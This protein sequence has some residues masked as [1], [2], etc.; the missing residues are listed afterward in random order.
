[1]SDI[2]SSYDFL[3]S[4]LKTGKIRLE[5]D[6]ASY[7]ELKSSRYHTIQTVIADLHWSAL[8]VFPS[9]SSDSMK[10]RL[11]IKNR[12][13]ETFK[14]KGKLSMRLEDK[15]GKLIEERIYSK[16]ME[17]SARTLLSRPTVDL[18]EIPSFAQSLRDDNKVILE[19]DIETF[20]K[21]E[22]PVDRLKEIG[23]IILNIGGRKLI[24]NRML[25]SIHSPVFR[26]L[27]KD[28]TITEYELEDVDFLDFATL[29]NAIVPDAYPIPFT[30]VEGVLK[31]AQKFEMHQIVKKCR[32]VIDEFSQYITQ[33]T[34]PCLF[35]RMQAALNVTD[36]PSSS[37]ENH[38]RNRVDFKGAQFVLQSN[39]KILAKAISA[40]GKMAEDVYL[41]V[42]DGGL[43]LKVLNRSKS[44]YCVFRFAPEFFNDCDLSLI[45]PSAVNVCRMSMKAAQSMFK[46]IHLNDKN[47]LACEFRVDPKSDTMG[48][49][50]GLSYDITR[51][52]NIKLLEFSGDLVRPKYDRNQYRNCTVLF[53]SILT[54]ILN[55][56]RNEGEVTLFCEKEYLQLKN[57]QTSGSENLTRM[58]ITEMRNPKRIRTETKISVEKLSRHNITFSTEISFSLKEFSAVVIF[59]EYLASE[60]CLYY[61]TP[62]KPL[63]IAV[64]SST[65]F[66]VELQLATSCPDDDFDV[67]G[68]IFGE[69]STK[70]P[71]PVKT[72]RRGSMPSQSRNIDVEIDEISTNR[73][74]RKIVEHTSHEGD[75][76]TTHN[77][78]WR[79]KEIRLPNQEETTMPALDLAE[80][81]EPMEV[82][83]NGSE[84]RGEFATLAVEP[85]GDAMQALPATPPP[86]DEMME[87]DAEPA[88]QPEEVANKR[89]N[90]YDMKKF[91]MKG[92]KKGGILQEDLRDQENNKKKYT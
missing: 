72:P 19:I 58:N 29:Q 50:L 42:T 91:A 81:D 71:S 66:D 47:F 3:P 10:T 16:E 59:A 12:E 77:R 13:F 5:M 46:G 51:T 69:N 40:L 33:T 18:F 90:I 84:L 23:D 76:E 85:E 6:N 65:S 28:S 38:Q 39:L 37:S 44:A 22:V 53:A 24:S 36:N 9:A 21:F 55:Q 2:L 4:N 35:F 86:H 54:P 49:Q 56:L 75:A 83:E 25:L 15:S 79:E 32:N 73:T 80:N 1:M 41:E 27:L 92:K 20:N 70:T 74:K 82:A 78:T 8:F 89:V 45:N 57:F 30:N 63:I 67:D 11:S 64:E 43:M 87:V 52:I 26:E 88:P 17:F 31:L 60:V 62:G 68:G 34:A 61:D 48:V 14:A 7:K